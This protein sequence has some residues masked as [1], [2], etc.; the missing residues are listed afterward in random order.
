[1]IQIILLISCAAMLIIYVA[2]RPGIRRSGPYLPDFVV[3]G[4]STYTL[5]AATL[6]FQGEVYYAGDVFLLAAI[7]QLSAC[8]GCV[9]GATLL[10]RRYP[11]DYSQ[12]SL[13]NY[14]LAKGEEGMIYVGLIVC[15][16][17][18]TVFSL[19]ILSN[20]GI[21]ALLPSFTGFG[22]GSGDLLQARKA[23]TN[24]TE[25]Y[26]APGFVKQFR[27][28]IAPVLLAA[29][30]LVTVRKRITG[31][32]LGIAVGSGLAVF[33]AM[34]LTGVRSNIFLL[35]VTLFLAFWFVQRLRRPNARGKPRKKRGGSKKSIL[36]IGLALVAYG[37]LT[38]MLG[39]VDAD[40]SASDLIVSLFGNLFE[41]IVIT[42]P[43]ENSLSYDVWASLQ[44]TTGEFWRADLA[45][46]LPGNQGVTLSNLLHASLGGSIEGN[47][48]LGMPADIW[49]N[50]GWGGLVILPALYAVFISAFDSALT[51]MRS[52]IAF[53][54]KV[55]LAVALVKI[56]SPFGFLLYGG[57]VAIIVFFGAK[58]LHSRKALKRASNT[59]YPASSTHS[60]SHSA[61]HYSSPSQYPAE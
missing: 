29:I 56:Y 44:G 31:I 28:L 49:V 21:A 50:W 11:S 9:M 33:V 19:Q 2:S 6:W 15:A 45:G 35:F 1:M 61:P 52:P 3:L 42:V 36:F 18:C 30:A 32:K 7:T 55:M 16:L 24:A 20:Q 57:A 58:F 43:R 27:D 14:H 47:S 5:G 34:L 59:A 17:V 60:A 13:A 25:G 22:G 23:I 51:R 10:K 46:A 8:A 54:V 37:A 40:N 53:G 41:R 12:Q 39:R 4:L 38:I 48:V 26:L